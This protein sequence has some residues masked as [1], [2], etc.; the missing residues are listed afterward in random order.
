VITTGTTVQTNPQQ[1]YILTDDSISGDVVTLPSTA[2]SG[3][4]IGVTNAEPFPVFVS[5]F[6]G[7]ANVF[8][9]GNLNN[10]VTLPSYSASKY[11]YNGTNW[12]LGV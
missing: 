9:A 1:Y 4:W 8:Y 2:V 5:T 11:I 7:S 6:S 12:Y 3:T 10:R